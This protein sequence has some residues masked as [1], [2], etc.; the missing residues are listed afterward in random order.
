MSERPPYSQSRV[1]VIDQVSVE[2]QPAPPASK[3]FP[4]IES[5]A[6]LPP[7]VKVNKD[8]RL[9]RY[10]FTKGVSLRNDGVGYGEVI[11]ETFGCYVAGAFRLES[12]RLSLRTRTSRTFPALD[13]DD[14]SY[15]AVPRRDVDSLASVAG[16]PSVPRS[17]PRSIPRAGKIPTDL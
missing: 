9:V 5:D 3:S 17:T 1:P 7:E 2:S 12:E 13:D 14:D 15:R 6:A 4:N 10:P 8:A 16:P 11:I